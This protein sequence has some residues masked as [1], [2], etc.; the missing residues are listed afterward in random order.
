MEKQSEDSKSPSQLIDEK[1]EELGD[2]RGQILLKVRNLIRQT[3]P[4]VVEEWKWRGTPVWSHDGMI[5]TGETY[6]N[7]VKMTF[8]KG[9]SLEDPMH[10]FNSSLEGNT[11]RAIDIHEGEEL[12][13]EA[14][15]ALIRAA[16]DLNKY[17]RKTS[18]KG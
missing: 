15:K 7:V 6:K 12:N 16:I 11:R 4:E 3:D 1:I 18:R 2:W 10:I 14:L 17:S 13:E 8:A 5:C 9:A